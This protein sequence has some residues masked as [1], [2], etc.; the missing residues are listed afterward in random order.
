MAGVFDFC[1]YSRVIEELAPDENSVMTMNGWMFAPKPNT[2][3]RPS[4][5]VTLHGLRWFMGNNNTLNITANPLINAGR[6]RAFYIQNRLYGKFVLNHEYLGP[7]QCR[8]AKA[9][10]IPAAEVN[11]AGLIKP[12]ELTLIQ[13]NPVWDQ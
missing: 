10:N 1:P 7:I 13:D 6:L 2:P 4:F 11:S 8:F 5:K 12:L 3:Y 9:V